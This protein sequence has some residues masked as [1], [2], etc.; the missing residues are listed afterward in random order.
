MIPLDWKQNHGRLAEALLGA[1]YA[2][3]A[4]NLYTDQVVGEAIERGETIR[5]IVDLIAS[6]AESTEELVAMI[7]ALGIFEG[8]RS[9]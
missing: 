3:S 7:W 6:E 1:D 9:R 2:G 5:N 4:R 8:G